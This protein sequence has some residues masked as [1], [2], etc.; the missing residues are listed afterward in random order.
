MDSRVKRDGRVIEA[1]GWYDPMA[2]G[3]EKQHELKIDRI[4]HWISKGAQPSETVTD[5]LIR[6]N[7]I[8]GAERKAEIA[9]RIEAKKAAAA[10]VA[11]AASGEKKDDAAKPA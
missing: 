10:K 2:K 11:A 9:A 1:L 5:L 6:Q 8:D 3:S 7:V 4:K